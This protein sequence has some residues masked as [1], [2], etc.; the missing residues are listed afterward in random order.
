MAFVADAGQ[1]TW[2]AAQSLSLSEGVRFLATPGLLALGYALPAAVGVAFGERAPVV[3][4]IGDGGMQLQI[5]ELQTIARA[6]LPVKV[7]VLNNRC[8]GLVRQFQ[9]EHFGGRHAATV[10]GYDTPD[11]ARVASAYGVEGHAI[12]SPAEVEDAIGALWS[13]PAR[14]ALLEV[15]IPLETAVWPFVPFGAGLSQMRPPR[16]S[17]ERTRRAPR[18]AHVR[19]GGHLGSPPALARLPWQNVYSVV[20][21]EGDRRGCARARAQGLIR[22]HRA[23]ADDLRARGR[24]R[25][26][27]RDGFE[28]IRAGAVDLSDGEGWRRSPPISPRIVSSWSTGRCSGLPILARRAERRRTLLVCLDHTCA[29]GWSLQVL[30]RTGRAVR[31]GH[32]FRRRAAFAGPPVRGLR[33]VG[34]GARRVGRGRAGA[35]GGSSACASPVSPVAVSRRP[36]LPGRTCAAADSCCGFRRPTPRPGKRGARFGRRCSF[37]SWPPCNPSSRRRTGNDDP[38]IG[39][40]AAARPRAARAWP[41]RFATR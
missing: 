28:P 12:G 22:R 41:A 25:A 13:D 30:A 10:S 39:T 19:A 4:V 8:H 24:R 33:S 32:G 40:R 37:C 14:P 2:W 21:I 6:Q 31:H 29:D 15:A 34:R 36:I 16:E 3:A 7:V 18:P 1:H 38:V 17:D 23:A 35:A 26:G 11:F 27:R 9:D 5:Q 20:D